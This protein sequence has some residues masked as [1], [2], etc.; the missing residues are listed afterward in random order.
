MPIKDTITL[1]TETTPRPLFL[2]VFDVTNCLPCSWRGVP[3]R[4]DVRRTRPPEATQIPGRSSPAGRSSVGRRPPACHNDPLGATRPSSKGAPSDV[5]TD[6]AQDLELHK[7]L[8][9]MVE[10]VPCQPQPRFSSRKDSRLHSRPAFDV[11]VLRMYRLPSSARTL[12]KMSFGP[13]HWSRISSTIRS[14]SPR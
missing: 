2:W 11:P 5:A 14:C 10:H 12:K 4:S 8:P 1:V 3:F 9:L 13:Y 6:W 7:V